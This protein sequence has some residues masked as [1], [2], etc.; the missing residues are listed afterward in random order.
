MDYRKTFKAG[1]A[2]LMACT[3][4]ACSGGSS[5][6]ETAGGTAAIKLGAS[7]VLC[8]RRGA[9]VKFATPDAFINRA[10]LYATSCAQGEL[11]L[12]EAQ[13][14]V[15]VRAN[16]KGI[17]AKLDILKQFLENATGYTQA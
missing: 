11:M 12:S 9:G 14:A 7:V 15:V 16:D 1:L 5:S 13:N 2:T 3:M 6:N 10:V 4:I 17:K 8:S